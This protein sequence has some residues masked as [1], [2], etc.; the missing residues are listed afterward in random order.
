MK[1]FYL[2]ICLLFLSLNGMAQII[3]IPDT[4][5]RTLLLSST[6]SNTIARNSIGWAIAVD[7]NNDSQIQL[8]EALNIAQINVSTSVYNTVNDI[9]D[10]TGIENFTNLKVLN[11]AGNQ[12]SSINIAS[13]TQLEEIKANNNL[14]TSFSFSGVTNLKKINFDHNQLTTI[15]TD[16]QVNL[17]ELFAYDN[18]LTSISFN[19]NPLLQNLRI[20]YNSL[21]NLDL[22]VLPSLIW[23]SCENNNLSSLNLSGLTALRSL[24]FAANQVSSIDLMG[25]NMLE[26]LTCN[27]NP[28]N[29]LNVNGRLN[30]YL[31]DVSYTQITSMDC[32]QSGVNVFSA[33]NCPNLQTI[34]LRNGVYSTSDPDMLFYAFSIHNN[35]QLDSICTDDGEQNQLIF[36][37]YNTSG[38]VQVYNGSSCNIPVAVT[39][40]TSDFDKSALKLYPN[41]TSGIINIEVSNN[42]PIKATITT[43]LGQTIMS[44]ENTIIDISSLT[45]GTYLIT[46]ETESGKEMQQIIKQ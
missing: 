12:I 43:I 36:T 45:K 33:N 6:S 44:S 19:N 27:G 40:G 37:D 20:S 2:S 18:Q 42:Q 22:S 34:N 17:T 16:N 13:L 1:N 23:A 11:C 15:N 7:T 30:L 25:L 3:T 4:N 21:T 35:P 24:N 29:A 26:Y 46:V 10:L 31:L 5:F 39:M 9:H 8:S 38:S 28:L 41:P 14:F 32:S